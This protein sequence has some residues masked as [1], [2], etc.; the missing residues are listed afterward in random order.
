MNEFICATPLF[1]ANSCPQDATYRAAVISAADSL[2]DGFTYNKPICGGARHSGN[3]LFPAAAAF[4]SRWESIFAITTGSSRQLL[5]ALLYLLHPC[6][7]M[8]AITLT[9]PPHSLQVSMSMLNT[10]FSLCA[11]V[12]DARCSAAVCCCV[13]CAVLVCLPVPRLA[14]VTNARTLLLGANTP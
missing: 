12:I 10:R 13:S 6:S 9:A 2:N 7:R 4:L 1:P 3:R 11:Q 14:G 8:Q 5:P